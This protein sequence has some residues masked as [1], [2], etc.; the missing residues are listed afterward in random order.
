MVKTIL[1]VSWM[2][3]PSIH[4]SIYEFENDYISPAPSLSFLPKQGRVFYLLLLQLLIAALTA[5]LTCSD[6][7]LKGGVRQCVR[8][9]H[10]LIG[11]SP[12][13]GTKYE[14]VIGYFR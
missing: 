5:K 6:W 1:L 13:Y 14:S 11:Y 8:S 9:P 3:S 2:V 10:Y 4:S 12:D 7:P